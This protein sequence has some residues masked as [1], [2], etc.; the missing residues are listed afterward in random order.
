MADQPKN[1]STSDEIDLGQLFQMIGRGFN[2]IGISFLKLFLYLKKNALVLGILAVVG[3]GL[4]YGLNQISRSKLKIEVIV[5]PN[6]ESK[7]YLY[8]VVAEI[9][10]N[11]RSKDS[12]FFKNIGLEFSNLGEFKISI[13][14]IEDEKNKEGD[15]EYL[16]LLEK[17]QANSEFMDII[18]S[19]L[20]N[21]STLN[22]RITFLFKD[23]SEGKIFAEKVMEYINS[24]GYFN[25]LVATSNQN[26][27]E[28]IER[29]ELFVKQIDELI[30]IYSQ[31]FNAQ[32]SQNIDGRIVLDNNEKMNVTGLFSLK[33]QIINNTERKTM[34]LKE[35]K[36]AINIINFGNAQRVKKDFFARGIVLVPLFLVGLFFAFSVIKYVNKKA[37][38]IDL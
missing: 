30:N 38:E 14:P 2:K 13:E 35:Q 15:L 26:A 18:K 6:L 9:E 23:L 28:R 4:G 19:E 25:D 1:N 11:I 17:F 20:S 33:N 7:N 36:E 37:M 27:K 34:E 31:S 22:H 29:N 32:S 5:K 21:K 24:N 12:V 8:D 3:V 16:K 10:S